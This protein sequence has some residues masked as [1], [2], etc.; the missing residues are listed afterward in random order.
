MDERIVV[1][2]SAGLQPATQP[3]IAEITK[4]QRGQ[5]ITDELGDNRD[6]KPDLSVGN[7]VHR[8][9]NGEQF[10]MLA[11]AAED[12]SKAETA[13]IPPSGAHFSPVAIDPL[14]SHSHCLGRSRLRLVLA[15][16]TTRHHVM[17]PRRWHHRL[18]LSPLRRPA[19]RPPWCSRQASERAPASPRA[20]MRGS[21]R[22]RPQRGRAR[23]VL[24]RHGTKDN[25]ILPMSR[26]IFSGQK[27]S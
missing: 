19:A 15:T 22:F 21:R 5:S 16:L 6:T 4:L 23:S 24:C 11:S 1:A 13:L 17:L 2:Q 20:R 12:R 25:K 3:R 27:L 9:A 14:C 7:G 26:K 8:G 18:Q 10:E